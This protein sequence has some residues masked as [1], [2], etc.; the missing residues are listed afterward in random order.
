MR[1]TH[2]AQASIFENY[3][4]HE[5]GVQLEE[6]S[7]I[8]DRY[9]EILSLVAED[10]IDQSISNFGRKGLS[11]ESVFR[12]LFLKQKL[13]ISYEQLAFHLSDSTTYR[14]FTRLP[15]NMAP[16]RSTLQA[17]IRSI[18]SETLEKINNLLSLDWLE[19]NIM[20]K[21]KIRIDSTVVKS[22]IAPPR[23]SQLLDDCIRVLSRQLKKCQNLTGVKI[24]FTDQRRRSKSLT[25]K[26][27]NAKKAEK[28]LLYPKLLNIIR[29][30]LNQV[31]KAINSVKSNAVDSNKKDKWIETVQHFVELA[32]KVIDQTQRRVVNGESVKS[33]EKI[34]SIFE[35][36]TDVIV[37]GFREVLYGHKINLSSECHGFITYLSIAT[38]N[39]SDKDLYLPVLN[40]HQ[41]ELKYSPNATVA[42]GGYA[43]QAN[44]IKGREAG[45]NRV[46]F[47][48]PVGVS[49]Q[50]M[51]V[52]TKTF[53]K[54]KDFRAG[55]EGNISEL[56]R[57]FGVDKAK[58]KG[59]EGFKAYVWSSVLSYNLTRLARLNCT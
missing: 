43:S 54:L 56:K 50:Q 23:D 16:S 34:V 33:S 28:D 57:A 40:H 5:F 24:R 38:G 17:T 39:T 6:V 18:K 30:T 44:V 2:V 53:K 25:F 10:L 29:I 1:E 22:N 14:T 41:D 49:L 7:N 15:N 35:E 9:P 52:K 46:V 42:D 47:N 55:V 36:H 26:I 37:K 45:I 19:R 32:H 3:S 11:V 59:F 13:R 21:D 20:S 8:L 31:G 58:W 4:K 12:C 48:K 27:F 51:G